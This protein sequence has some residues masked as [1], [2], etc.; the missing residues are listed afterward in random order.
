MTKLAPNPYSPYADADPRFRHLVPS[1]FGI[2][3]KAGVLAVAACGG[4]AVVPE[5]TLGDATDA[6]KEGRL[7]DLPEGLCPNRLAV[8][9]GAG[10]EA[11]AHVSPGECSECGDRTLH[12]SCCALCRQEMHDQWRASQA[13]ATEA[14]R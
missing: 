2:P 14:T 12:G 9:T 13:T 3:P 10:I 5:G 7:A 6:L 11:G 8:A 1:L 4:M